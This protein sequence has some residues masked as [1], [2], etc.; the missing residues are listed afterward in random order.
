MTEQ[1]SLFDALDGLQAGDVVAH[2]LE[3]ELRGRIVAIEGER[4]RLRLLTWPTT[5][6]RRWYREKPMPALVINL[7][8][9][10]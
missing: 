9:A 8:L 6:L 4:A 5:W 7:V 1:M 3:P 2:R 10:E